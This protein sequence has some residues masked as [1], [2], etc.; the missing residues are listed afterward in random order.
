VDVS[1]PTN[2]NPLADYKDLATQIKS[3]KSDPATQLLVAGIFGWPLDGDTTKATY[4]IAPVPNPNSAD[5]AHPTIFDTWP[6]CYDPNHAPAAATADKTTGFDPVAAGWG[7]TPG[8]RMSAFIDEFG[9]NGL[10]YSICQPDFQAAMNGI[11]TA[12]S[13][14]LQNLCVNYKLWTDPNGMHDC[15]VAYSRPSTDPKNPANVED[16]NGMPECATG[17]TTNVSENCW[18]LAQDTGKCPINGQ[19]V[20]IARSAADKTQYGD[21]LPAG[22]K[23]DMQC[24]TCTDFMTPDPVTGQLVPLSGC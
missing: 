11:G 16:P 8:L 17:Q 18:Y 9:N 5:M 6:I 24:R 12:I 4:K 23:V 20:Q 1:Q 21:Q 3:L 10:K 13:K 14:H 7:A 19:L 15:R 2:C 22:T